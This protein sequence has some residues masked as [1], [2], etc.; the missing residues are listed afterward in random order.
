ME[1]TAER[2]RTLLEINNAIITHLTPE[3][4]LRSVSEILRRVVP[5]SGAALTI[6]NP[7]NETFRYL[8]MEG[9]SPRITFEPG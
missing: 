4:L 8:A 2:Y 3:A 9:A 5:Y 7:Q 1:C 6:Y